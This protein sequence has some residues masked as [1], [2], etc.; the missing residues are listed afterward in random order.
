[1]LQKRKIISLILVIMLLTGTILN[2]NATEPDSFNSKVDMCKIMSP[3]EITNNEIKEYGNSNIEIETKNINF[4]TSVKEEIVIDN[5]A[6]ALYVTY[7]NPDAAL[8]QIKKN[9]DNLINEL[10][11]FYNLEDFSEITWHTY[12]DVF[13]NY[14]TESD[15]TVYTEES[16]E[17]NQLYSFFDI[18]ENNDIN[19]EL[20]EIALSYDNINDLLINEDFTSQLPSYVISDLSTEESLDLNLVEKT[21]TYAL[22]TSAAIAYA[23]TYA[24]S[25]NQSEYPY[26]S[27]ADCANFASQIMTA[28]G[29]THT[30]LWYCKNENGSWRYTYTWTVANRF[31]N[32]HGVDY[33]T[34]SFSTFSQ[35]LQKGDFITYDITSDGSWDHIGFVTAIG[36]YDSSIG[37]KTFCVAQ[38]TTNY[39]AWTSGSLNGW[40]TLENNN[41]NIKFAYIRL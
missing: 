7:D 38:H 21:S 10:R 34:T 32:H 19:E 13:K 18:Y 36:S 35:K 11:L 15:I 30:T 16:Y 39:H 4:A 28:G 33:S 31:A 22:S 14:L 24:T 23:Q 29:K 5:K 40:D 6:L 25:P 17:Y 2:V 26:F 1:M 9:C 12:Y 8:T 27:N 41:E 37:H 20:K 3:I